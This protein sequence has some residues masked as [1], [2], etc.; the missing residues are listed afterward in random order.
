M[1]DWDAIQ[2]F[3]NCQAPVLQ[4]NSVLIQRV[5]IF[6]WHQERTIKYHVTSSTSTS[7]SSPVRYASLSVLVRIG[8]A[9]DSH[10]ES[11]EETSKS[12]KKTGEKTEN[13]WNDCIDSFD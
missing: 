13:A 1:T 10:L 9:L 12:S 5:E 8:L 7:A 3:R 6:S 2:I 11:T 4:G